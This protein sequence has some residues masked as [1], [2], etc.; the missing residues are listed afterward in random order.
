MVILYAGISFFFLGVLIDNEEEIVKRSVEL[1]GRAVR[2]DIADMD[3]RLLDWSQWDDIYEF[4]DRPTQEFI[5]SNFLVDSL[6]IL[7]VSFSI[8][9]DREGKVLAKQ[10]MDLSTRERAS[11]PDEVLVQLGKGNV[12]TNFTSISEGHSGIIL[13]SSGPAFIATRPI[14]NSRGEGP[15]RGTIAFIRMIDDSYRQ[16][17]ADFLGYPLTF[18]FLGSAGFSSDFS[19]AVRV[20]SDS[21]ET[22]TIVGDASISG[23][24][25]VPDVFGGTTLFYKIDKAIPAS[26]GTIKLMAALAFVGFL[27]AVTL[28]LF[29]LIHWTV[30]SRVNYLSGALARAK[31][32]GLSKGGIEFFGSDEVAALAGEINSLL[33]TLLSTREKSDVAERRFETIA[34]TIPAFLWM[35]GKGRECLFASRQSIEFL[36][37]T[38][39]QENF[40]ESWQSHIHPDD[41]GGCLTKC[42]RAFEFRRPLTMEY[43]VVD[44]SGAY[45][46]VLDRSVPFSTSGSVF[47]GFLH[48]AID[49]T[50]RKEIEEKEVVKRKEAERLNAIMVSREL[51]MIDLKKEIRD[52]R[53][54]LGK[55]K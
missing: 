28:I 18:A 45:R 54:N 16:G 35:I 13:F 2:Q 27:L 34:D 22:R 52:L 24:G 5:D 23:Y 29:F 44:C 51:R 20:L 49:I 38:T 9:V 12:L 11:V 6:D 30:L 7:D 55:K 25:F 53:E 48:V 15:S 1:V 3:S 33:S 17:L 4:A 37:N 50:D 26:F 10:G 19:E 47:L 36:G 31:K 8:V 43:R 41:V 14:V 21:R 42:S 40:L 46:W 32:K 39:R